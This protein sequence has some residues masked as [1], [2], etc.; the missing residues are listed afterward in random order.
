[1]SFMGEISDIG[2]ADLLY[3][4]AL[5]QQSGRLSVVANGDEVSLYIERGKMVLVTSSNMALRLGRMLVRLDFLTNDRLKEALRR[6]E[7]GGG[8]RPLGS[9]L[10]DGGFIT[11]R[12]LHQC[13]EEQCIEVLARIIAAESGIFVFHR[14]GRVSPK[15]EIVP[16]NSDRILLEATRRTDEITTLRSRLPDESAPL[17]LGP[18]IEND[19]DA[20]SDNEIVVASALF[21]KPTNLRELGDR[22][23]FDDVTLWRTVLAMWERGWIIAGQTDTAFTGSGLRQIHVAAD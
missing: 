10:I 19:A 4:L 23:P 6:Q 13:I 11:E 15:T 14:D 17:L 5:R 1:M 8:K 7:Q 21:E 12:Q 18:A 22:V 9:I 2:V 20:M 3:L 16:L